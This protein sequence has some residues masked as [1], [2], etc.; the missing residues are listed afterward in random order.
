V[1]PLKSSTGVP[2]RSPYPAKPSVRPSYSVI[3]WFME[4]VI[5][6]FATVRSKMGFLHIPQNGVLNE[7][8]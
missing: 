7:I 4:S 3:Y 5:K 8:G 6:I 1:A 2:A